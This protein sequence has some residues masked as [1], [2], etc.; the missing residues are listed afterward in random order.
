MEIDQLRV[1]SPLS[2]QGIA[3]RKMLSD[4]CVIGLH[5]EKLIVDP[6]QNMN[7]KRIVMITLQQF[8]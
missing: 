2:S 4:L 5:D 1:I 8:I 7:N 6:S 3:C